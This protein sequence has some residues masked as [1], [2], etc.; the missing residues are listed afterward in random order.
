MCGHDHL[1]AHLNRNRARLQMSWACLPYNVQAE[2]NTRVKEAVSEGLEAGEQHLFESVL[3][4][5]I[6]SS[7]ER[8]HFWKLVSLQLV[9]DHA[10]KVTNSQGRHVLILYSW[11]ARAHMHNGSGSITSLLHSIV[12]TRLRAYA[13][14]C[15]RRGKTVRQ[16]ILY[17]WIPDAW[18]NHDTA[19]FIIG[20]LPSHVRANPWWDSHA[21]WVVL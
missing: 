21:L 8:L 6:T 3:L 4:L 14:F 17:I 12:V 9:R 19:T 11:N 18:D 15:S 5:S 20:K 16:N 10:I 1:L 13:L 2:L 7:T